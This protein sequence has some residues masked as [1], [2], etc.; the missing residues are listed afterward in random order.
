MADGLE[1]QM[2]PQPTTFHPFA[3]R[4]TDDAQHTLFQLLQIS[5]GGR[6]APRAADFLRLNT[7]GAGINFRFEDILGRTLERQYQYR[8]ELLLDLIASLF[9]RGRFS[10]RPRRLAIIPWAKVLRN[11]HC[12]WLPDSRRIRVTQDVPPVHFI[13]RQYNVLLPYRYPDI[14][15]AAFATVSDIMQKQPAYGSFSE[16]PQIEL[17]RACADQRD[18]SM[19]FVACT[20]QG[21]PIFADDEIEKCTHSDR[22]AESLLRFTMLL[23]NRYFWCSEHIE[24]RKLTELSATDRVIVFSNELPENES[25]DNEMPDGK[26]PGARCKVIRY[27]PAVAQSGRF[28]RGRK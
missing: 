7:S 22:Y 8:H 26:L 10:W 11:G 6:I 24:T 12:Y 9:W 28:G 16:I 14:E 1:N 17:Q 25:P 13:S 4:L 20:D 5:R 23:I 2:M 27:D 3:G 19:A 21:G 18:Q 15:D